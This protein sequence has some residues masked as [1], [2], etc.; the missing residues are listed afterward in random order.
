MLAPIAVAAFAFAPMACG[1]SFQAI[2][3]GD[4]HFE[5]CYA[6]DESPQAALDKKS[7]CWDDWSRRY[8]YGQTRD[9]IQYARARHDALSR[10]QDAPT[11]E[12]IM[13]AAPGG[14]EG[15]SGVSAPMPTS[16]FAP[17][18]KTLNDES[19]DSGIA[20]SAPAFK[21]PPVPSAAASVAPAPPEP[22][23][24]CSSGCSD[25]WR[26]CGDSCKG[27]AC[28]ACPKD[29]RKC[30]RACFKDDGVKKKPAAPAP[31]PAASATP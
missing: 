4:A 20:A 25:A 30:M 9:R 1:P 26:S 28:D 22:E 6:L 14:G 27:A 5:K 24:Y 21:L 29:Y 2:Y 23:S 12:S 31:A 13:A 8:T 10:V 16:A 3:E 17:P 11:D 19:P 7:A 15:K 18:P